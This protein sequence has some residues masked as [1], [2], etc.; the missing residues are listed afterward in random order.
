MVGELNYFLCLQVK[1][2]EQGIYINQAKYAKNLVKRSGPEKIAHARTPR[3]T[4]TKFRID[5]SSQLVA[6]IQ[7]RNMIGY[8]LYITASHPNISFSVGVCAR[9]QAYPKL[10]HL[11][12][13]KR[14]IKYVNGTSNFGLFY[15]KYSNV[16]LVGYFDV[17]WVGNVDDRKNTTWGCFYVGTNLVA[18]MSK[19]KN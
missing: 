2:T 6:I 12:V 7:Y 18:W 19:N 17:D 16:S 5:P 14:I 15:S 1:Q 11:I 10:S 13:V 9:F 3:A 8:L 4:N